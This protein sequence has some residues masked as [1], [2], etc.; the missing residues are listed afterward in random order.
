MRQMLRNSRIVTGMIL[1]FMAIVLFIGNPMEA[2]AYIQTSGTVVSESAIIRKSADGESKAIASIVKGDKVTINNEEKDA[3]GVVWYKVFVDAH[4]L[5]YVRGDLIQKK[6]SSGPIQQ[7]ETPKEEKN[8]ESKPQSQAPAKPSINLNVAIA[9]NTKVVPVESQ[10]ASVS[11]DNVRVRSE[12][13]AESEIVTQVRKATAVT[14]TGQADGTDGKVWYLV[15]FIAEDQE[16]RGFIRSDFVKLSTDIVVIEETPE[17]E[18]PVVEPE[19]P[20]PVVNSD[21]ELRYEANA[22]GINEWY[23]YNN[24]EGVKNKLGE[25]LEA[26]DHN[27]QTVI[28]AEAQVK[29]QKIVIVVLSIVLVFLA[30]AITMLLFKLRDMY[31][32]DFNEYDE[33]PEMPRRRSSSAP[34]TV[35]PTRSSRPVPRPGAN[36]QQRPGTRPTANRQQRPASRPTTNGQQR[37]GTR[38]TANGQQRPTS[39]PGANGQQRPTSRIVTNEQ[40][41]PDSKSVAEEYRRPAQ[42]VG[43][44]SQRPPKN[45]EKKEAGWQPKNF[46]TDDDDMEFEFLNWDGDER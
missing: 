38:P 16:V 42:S 5:G 32:D 44:K 37:P 12:A 20:E 29:K 22:E 15:S 36:G 10:G 24:I 7:V 31:Y 23:L 1:F 8:E 39:R 41:R 13:S 6:G 28:D 3:N 43:E 21:Y 33:E 14:V 34:R 18:E 46:L 40:S 30:L 26:A 27:S 4:T 2:N 9:A 11:N 45:T 19:E 17:V 25:I 35:N